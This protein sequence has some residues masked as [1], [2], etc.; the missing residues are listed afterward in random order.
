[1]RQ[2]KL[3]ITYQGTHYSGWQL[4]ASGRTVQ[5]ELE[6]AI[7]KMTGAH[8]RI[9]GAGRTDAGVHA[10]AQ[11][12][13]FKTAALHAPDVFIRALNANL[14][15]D[16]RIVAAEETKPGFSPRFHAKEKTYCYYIC[17]R[18]TNSAFLSD[19]TWSAPYSINIEPMQQAAEYLIG[20]HDFT[21]FQ[22]AGCGAKHAIRK[23]KEINIKEMPA[24]EFLG[25]T[26]NIP[27]I[28]IRI[29]ADAFLRHMVR[30]IVGTLAAVG[31]GKYPPE[32]I[33]D[34]LQA[35]DRQEA[36]VTAPSSGLFLESITY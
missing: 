5:G 10:L 34:I 4:Q 15:A 9:Y 20:K 3:T 35:R 32:R 17:K 1:M 21:S 18:D 28:S 29:T 31:N 13:A 19:Y 6:K 7:K 12:A 11:V 24:T 22:A 26:F 16:I 30:N 14:P 27:L 36:G 33:I 25:F 23:I 8:S 2:I